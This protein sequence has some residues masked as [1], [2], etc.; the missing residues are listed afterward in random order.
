MDSLD[1][2][3]SDLI[4]AFHILHKHQVLDE[5][6]EIS[7]RNPQDSSTFFTSN[8][9]AILVSSKRD[10]NQWYVADGSPVVTPYDGC[11]T[12]E[13]VSEHSEHYTHS[14]IYHQYPGVQSVVHSHCSSAIVYG[15]CNNWVSLLQ[16]SYLMA[17]FL[18]TSPPIFDIAKVYGNLPQSHPRNLLINNQDLGDELAAMFR[19]PHDN[20]MVINGDRIDFPEHKVVFQRGHGYVTWAGSI[21]DAV[22][23]AIH[24]RRNADIQTTAMTQRDG[25]NQDVVYL[26][27]REAKDCE[28]TIN[29]ASK[30]HWLSWMVEADRSGFY[31]NDLMSSLGL[32]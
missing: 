2:L 11:R 1:R 16:P 15:L 4:T 27:E 29:N 30:E 3:L 32:G 18:G 31:R 24:I 21:A 14:S 10:L 19:R 6:G 17:G 28:K 22:W 7:V 8:L 20:G 13:Q 25:I 9:P 5:H 23:R 26:S 12:I